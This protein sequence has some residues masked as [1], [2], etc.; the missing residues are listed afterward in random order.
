M[1]KKMNGIDIGAL[2]DEQEQQETEEE[3]VAR[4]DEHATAGEE[5]PAGE[6]EGGS[7][8]GRGDGA[9]RD[10]HAPKPKAWPIRHFDIATPIGNII[11]NSEARDAIIS[12]A[13]MMC[14]YASRGDYPIPPHMPDRASE[15]IVYEKSVVIY[16]NPEKEYTYTTF[17]FRTTDGITVML[18]EAMEYANLERAEKNVRDYIDQHRLLSSMGARASFIH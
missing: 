11:A 6:P 4:S 1:V 18:D 12:Y 16:I 17:I 8:E 2:I 3:G 10:D 15:F 13:D 14:Q 5:G 7:S 9:G